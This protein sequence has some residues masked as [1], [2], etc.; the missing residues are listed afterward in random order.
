LRL[1]QQESGPVMDELH[2]W[3]RQQLDERNVEPNSSLGA[4]ISYMLKHWEKLTLF[5]RL[6]GAP[7]DNN[8]CERA[9]K[10]AWADYPVSLQLFAKPAFG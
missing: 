3:L 8:I 10:K 2:R 1:H 7:L 6:P 9:L 5:L 4:A